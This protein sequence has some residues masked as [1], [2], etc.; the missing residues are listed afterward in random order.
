MFNKHDVGVGVR[1]SQV[2]NGHERKG[3]IMGLTERETWHPAAVQGDDAKCPRERYTLLD[4]LLY[5]QRCPRSGLT[6]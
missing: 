6:D 3:R 1:G 4:R 5:S 2:S